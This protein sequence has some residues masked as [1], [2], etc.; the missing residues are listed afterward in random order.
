[1]T[2]TRHYLNAPITEA[3]IDLRV[4][5]RTGLKL[6]ELEQVVSGEEFAYPKRDG[7]FEVV[8]KMEVHS[9]VSASA[10]VGQTQT[11]FKFTS[12]DAKHIWQSRRNGFTFSRLAPYESWQP[13]RDEA[14][15]LWT[16]YRKQFEPLSIVRLAVRYINRIDI[17]GDG[18]ELKDYFRTS[19][20]VSED[21]PQRLAGF[22][23][24]L[25]IPQEDLQGQ[26][27]INQTIVPPANEG[28]VS[29]VLDV[30]LFR[31]DDVPNDEPGIWRFFEELHVRK[32]EVFEACITNKTREL[33]DECR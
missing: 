6:E 24:Q 19:P 21:L 23:M 8:G 4:Q 3:I 25:R 27:L 15:R 22:F 10:S 16:R 1:M 14:C 5:P 31:S 9:G 32:N 30:D 33:F 18:I 7:M 17:P 2:S 26:L 11:G 12:D 13:F 20:E 28:V 29:V